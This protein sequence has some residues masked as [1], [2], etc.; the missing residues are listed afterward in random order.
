MI[1]F[2]VTSSRRRLYHLAKI[3]LFVFPV[4]FASPT[5]KGQETGASTNLSRPCS[6]A[7]S[8][9]DTDC[10]MGLE[11]HI[12]FYWRADPVGCQ[13]V[14]AKVDA[15]IQAGGDARFRDLYYNERCAR[16]GMPH[17]GTAAIDEEGYNP[18]H[19]FTECLARPG[20]IDSYCFEELGRH[21]LHPRGAGS[22]GV[23]RRSTIQL[24]EEGKLPILWEWLFE[25]ERC[26]R[27]GM[28]RYDG[29]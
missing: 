4:V 13:A 18:N 24:V 6:T 5:A 27:L 15:I 8:D 23:Q 16:L 22:C 7:E 29:E 28:Q 12:R 3:G 1:I 11:E 19:P 14:G 26:W 10:K 9:R 2:S 25:N 21:M 17:S 20:F